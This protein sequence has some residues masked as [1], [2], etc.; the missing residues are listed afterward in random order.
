MKKFLLTA[1]VVIFAG[2][3][4]A[5]NVQTY[6][7]PKSGG[8]EVWVDSVYN[9]SN[10]DMDA[11]D[12]VVWTVG[13]STGDNDLWVTTTTSQGAAAQNLVAGVVYPVAI[14]LGDVGSIA[15]WGTGVSVDVNASITTAGDELCA[16]TTAGSAG[17]CPATDAG[18]YQSFGVC[19]STPSSSSCTALITIR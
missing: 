11:G 19:N 14:A 15:I 17:E 6:V 8:P 7:D 13:D 10:T 12:V 18:V 5:A 2:I 3:A 4:S 1:L 16:S 9:A